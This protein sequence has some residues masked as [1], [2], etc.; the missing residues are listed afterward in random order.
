MGLT[1]LH[2]DNQMDIFSFPP[3]PLLSFLIMVQNC[4]I[5][6]RE[7][8]AKCNCLVHNIF[9]SCNRDGF[10]DSWMPFFSL[11]P[12]FRQRKCAFWGECSLEHIS[13]LLNCFFFSSSFL[14]S[15]IKNFPSIAKAEFRN[16]PLTES[17]L[18]YSFKPITCRGLYSFKAWVTIFLLMWI[19]WSKIKHEKVTWK[20]I[21]TQ[22]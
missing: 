8:F 6:N 10:I 9:C 5:L 3:P 7:W 12:K 13:P 18:Y 1:L 11:F 21:T 14:P 15:S 2:G 17:L 20:K 4:L 16:S 19:E 22:I